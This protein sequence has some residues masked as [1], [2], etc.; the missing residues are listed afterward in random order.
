VT[1]FVE[2][3]AGRAANNSPNNACTRLSMAKKFPSLYLCI[4]VYV[5]VHVHFFCSLWHVLNRCPG[6]EYIQVSA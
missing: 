3:V 1:D 5:R 6:H 2:T 4:G